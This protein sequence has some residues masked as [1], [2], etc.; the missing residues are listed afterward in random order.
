M[1]NS[2]LRSLA[3]AT[4]TT[5]VEADG[6]GACVP[7]LARG[8]VHSVFTRACNIQTHAGELLTLLA[9]D[10]GN[11]PHGI[12]IAAPGLLSER[13]RPGQD[14]FLDGGRLCVP[15]AGL[16]ADFSRAAIWNGSLDAASTMLRIG[17][18]SKKISPALWQVR[19]VLREQAPEQGIAILLKGIAVGF[20]ALERALAARLMR[21]LPA[22]AHATHARKGEAVT[23]AVSGLVGLGAGLTPSGDDFIVGYLAALRCRAGRE[24]GIGA[25]LRDSAL[26]LERAIA[27]THAISRQMLRDAVNGRFS[28]SLIDVVRAIHGAGDV[29]TATLQALKC[30]HSS[31][32][33]T[34]CGLLFGLSPEMLLPSAQSTRRP[35]RAGREPY[36]RAA[37]TLAC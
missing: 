4:V 9:A 14:T 37:T 19:N 31:G 35:A 12:R 36:G 15:A 1:V 8:R 5:T 18:D 29:V 21:V 30:G 11:Q 32:A 13:L 26:P 27:H 10:L 24:A 16:T 25:L 23:A 20:P 28:E 33:D 3:T 17:G 34:L 7:A 6:V 22:L 2:N